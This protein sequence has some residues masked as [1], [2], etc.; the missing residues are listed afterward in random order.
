MDNDEFVEL[1]RALFEKNHAVTT[2]APL[3][4]Q[5]EQIALNI[6]WFGEKLREVMGWSDG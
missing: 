2:F 5:E 1:H 4:E 3:E 6:E